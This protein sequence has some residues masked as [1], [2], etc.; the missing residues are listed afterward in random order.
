MMATKMTKQTIEIEGLPEGWRA[1]A[2]RVPK[3]GEYAIVSG[4]AQ[5]CHTY[6]CIFPRL[7]VQK[8]KTRRI[9]LEETDRDRDH[10]KDEMITIDDKTCV[11]VYGD[12]IWRIVEEE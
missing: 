12:K 10:M 7:V 1:V 11:E 8:T 5:L 6:H 4:E 9:V 2:F 3:E